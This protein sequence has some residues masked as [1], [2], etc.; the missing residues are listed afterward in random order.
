M[1]YIFHL[2]LAKYP[3]VWQDKTLLKFKAVMLTVTILISTIE[4]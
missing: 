3:I 4:K 2:G 1:I